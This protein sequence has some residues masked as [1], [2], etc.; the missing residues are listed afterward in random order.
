MKV[1]VQEENRKLRIIQ[2]HRVNQGQGS[3][4]WGCGEPTGIVCPLMGWKAFV[5]AACTRPRSRVGT[6]SCILFANVNSGRMLG[7]RQGGLPQRSPSGGARVPNPKSGLSSHQ[8]IRIVS[9][10]T[11]TS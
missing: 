11:Q 7:R 3:A 10:F 1:L 9:A 5:S 2:D 8:G 6:D 4:G